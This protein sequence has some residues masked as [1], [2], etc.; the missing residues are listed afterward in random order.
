MH[1]LVIITSHHCAPCAAYYIG[2]LRTE[3]DLLHWIIAHRVRSTT[4]EH[5]A[6]SASY[7]GSL[8]TSVHPSLVRCA[9]VCVIVSF[10]HQSAFAS[11]RARFYLPLLPPPLPP[12]LS[13]LPLLPPP[14]PPP[15]P[16][17]LSGL[18]D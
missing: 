3:C 13:G 5:Y 18:L 8:R 15:L 2:S 11:H 1:Q 10:I 16:P 7:I 14:L 12:L 9:H 17:L 4:L 6:L